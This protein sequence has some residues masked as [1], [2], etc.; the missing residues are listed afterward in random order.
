MDIGINRW[1]IAINI[2]IGSDRDR[3]DI[4]LNI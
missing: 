2:G 4:Y 3:G 1:M